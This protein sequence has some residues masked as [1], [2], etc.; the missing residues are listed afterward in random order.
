MP[1]PT[2]PPSSR[3]GVLELLRLFRDDVAAADQ[4]G[5]IC[6]DK[7]RA[8]EPTLKA[9]EVLPIEVARKPGTSPSSKSRP[10]SVG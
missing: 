6:L 1:D 10:E 2:S 4:Y 9:F 7:A 5:A 8:V 3:A